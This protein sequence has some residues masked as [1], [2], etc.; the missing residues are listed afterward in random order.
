MASSLH[1]WRGATFYV[2]MFG[3][4]KPS[5]GVSMTFGVTRFFGPVKVMARVA[6]QGTDADAQSQSI[7]RRCGHQRLILAMLVSKAAYPS[8][9]S[10]KDGSFSQKVVCR[11]NN[12]N[13]FASQGLQK[14]AIKPYSTNDSSP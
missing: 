4:R 7:F 3:P 2:F 1:N 10:L 11:D 8:T 9:F 14:A 6:S 5:H 13:Q 12:S